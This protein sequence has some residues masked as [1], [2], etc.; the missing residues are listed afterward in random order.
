MRPGR[1]GP[2][3]PVQATGEEEMTLLGFPAEFE[4]DE[5][6]ERLAA[7]LP[8]VPRAG[9]ELPGETGA[10]AYVPAA[11]PETATGPGPGVPLVAVPRSEPLAGLALLLAGVAAVVSL[12]LPWW[13]GPAVAGLTLVR[14]GLA[15]LASGPGALA[16]SGLWQPV[17]VVLGGGVLFLVGLALFR[18][19]RSHRP[20]GLLALLVTLAAAS[21]VVVPVANANWTV[22]S[23]GAGMWCAV[24][25][26][27]LGGLG[28]LKAMLTAP[29]VDVEAG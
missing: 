26:V 27:L 28:A 9:T 12:W 15:I 17:V 2:L 11:P 24:A 19:A 8:A 1:T 3:P 16:R 22:G 18:R 6:A 14:Q 25:V 5:D 7:R 29:G 13:R 20:A 21:G 10:Q 23:L 4:T